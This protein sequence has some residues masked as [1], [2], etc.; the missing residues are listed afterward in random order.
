M[1][2]S[3]RSLPLE[4]TRVAPRRSMNRNRRHGA[5]L[6]ARTSILNAL[7]HCRKVHIRNDE[8]RTRRPPPASGRMTKGFLIA[9]NA[10]VGAWPGH[11]PNH[12]LYGTGRAS[13]KRCHD[14]CR[15]PLWLTMPLRLVGHNT[16]Q[17]CV[18]SVSSGGLQCRGA[19]PYRGLFRE[20]GR[21][22]QW[23]RH[24]GYAL[25]SLRRTEFASRP[26]DDVRLGRL[27]DGLD[28]PTFFPCYRASF[29][30]RRRRFQAGH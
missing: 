8:Y 14:R 5:H 17:D 26:L 24:A 4:H 12:G 29:R 7:N 19:L 1:E 30:F 18:K 28:C 11:S 22:S 21:S 2:P 27:V 10:G 6:S 25:P 16:A 15:Q 20:R 23:L 9:A 13:V 3:C